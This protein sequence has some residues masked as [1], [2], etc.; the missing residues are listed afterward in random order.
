MASTGEQK[1]ACAPNKWGGANWNSGGGQLQFFLPSE[2]FI[3]CSTPVLVYCKRVVVDVNCFVN[4]VCA[5]GG[6]FTTFVCRKITNIQSFSFSSLL[7]LSHFPTQF[8]LFPV[9]SSVVGKN[10]NFKCSY[11]IWLRTAHHCMSRINRVCKIQSLFKVGFYKTSAHITSKF[12]CA[13]FQESLERYR[14]ATTV[15]KLLDVK[16]TLCAYSMSVLSK[17]TDHRSSTLSRLSALTK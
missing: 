14:K 13:N 4:I 17:M 8:R 3:A 5:N 1:R 7:S 15:D 9:F 10:S 16:K 6:I 12:V 2:F 11:G